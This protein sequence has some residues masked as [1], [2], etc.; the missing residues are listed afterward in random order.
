MKP[1]AAF[2][3]GATSVTAL[4]VGL[5]VAMGGLT[6]QTQA[7][8]SSATA[9]STTPSTATQTPT[10]TPSSSATANAAA[11]DT[12]E[13]SANSG[14]GGGSSGSNSAGIS[15]TFHGANFVDDEGWGNVQVDVVFNNGVITDVV[16][17]QAN[18]TDGRDRAFPILRQETLDAQSANVSTVSRATFTSMAYINSVQSALDAA[19]F[20]G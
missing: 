20:T 6:T 7:T 14:T 16:Y 10:S 1:T 9:E 5:N 13:T 18:A 15:G 12:T 11:Q 2:V 3:T 4:V 19:G 8:T 17:V